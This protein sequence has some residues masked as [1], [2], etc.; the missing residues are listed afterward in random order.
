MAKNKKVKPTVD[1]QFWFDFSKEMVESASTT[2]N[3]AAA[4]L[5]QLIAWLWGVYTASAAV[6]IALSKTSYPLLVV[7]LIASP[8]AILIF[9]YW[10][11]VWVQMPVKVRFDP[12]IPDDIKDAYMRGVKMKGRKLIC[13]I[14]LS[15]AAALLV[16][17]ALI[18][19]SLSKQGAAPFFEAYCYKE[20]K[21][22]FIAL[23]GQFPADKK[24]FLRIFPIPR[25]G[26]PVESKKI[27]YITTESGELNTNIK[28]DFIADRYEVIAKWM[29]NDD[30]LHSLRRTVIPEK[31]YRKI[32]E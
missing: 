25:F 28:L 26:T 19:A 17:I 32:T 8:S 1:D 5:Q 15:L 2:R 11:T 30:L 6:G 18:A 16:S 13:A 21:L 12:R 22:D 23:S 9:A 29:E 10:F 3:K 20:Q 4:K 31:N 24:I 27:V 7:V 14:G